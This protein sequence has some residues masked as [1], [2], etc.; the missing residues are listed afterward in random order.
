[1]PVTITTT[2]T[3]AEIEII[4]NGLR[5]HNFPHLGDVYRTDIACFTEDE[6]GVKTGGLYG[7]IFGHWLMVKFLWVDQN[8]KGRGLGSQLLLQAEAFAR[9]KGCHACLLDTFSFQ[10]KPFYEKLGYEVQMI[11]HDHP[12]STE[13]YYLTKLLV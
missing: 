7:E 6:H 12:V 5:E 10:A 4:R 2:P 8:V 11:L 1:M 3:E 13:R 9:E